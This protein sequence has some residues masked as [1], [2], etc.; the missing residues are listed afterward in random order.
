MKEFTVTKNDAGQRLDRF[1]ARQVPT[2]P[3]CALQ[4]Y[5]RT[6][7]IKLNGH[8]AKPD[9]RVSEGD[10]VRLYIPDEFFGKPQK[11]NSWLAVTQPKLDIVYEDQNILLV[12]KKPGVLCHAAEGWSAD[13]LIAH[14]QAHAYQLGEWDPARENSFAPALCNRIDRGTGGIVIAAKNAEALRVLDEKIRQR[15]IDKYYLCVCTGIPKPAAGKLT[16]YIFKDSIKNMVYVREKPEPGAS[17]AETEYKTLKTKSGLSLVECRLLTGRTHQIRAQM[18]HAG[19]PLLGDGKY[20][21]ERLNRAYG[22]NRQLLWSYRLSFCF[23]TDAGVLQYLSDK[24]FTVP[25]IFFA[26]KY[27]N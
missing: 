19:W 24:N 20:G 18:A 7:D 14:I 8:W 4:K 16:G 17:L 22:E 26:E 3:S 23:T 27:F 12:N 25:K 1:A 15:E 5:F 11:D 10:A 2:L 21:S 6:K 9:V 13:T